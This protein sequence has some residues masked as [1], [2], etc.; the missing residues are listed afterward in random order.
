MSDKQYKFCYS[1]KH[2]IIQIGLHS[3]CAREALKG[4]IDGVNGNEASAST[5]QTTADEG[6]KCGHGGRCGGARKRA[7]D[8][9]R[10]G[11][12]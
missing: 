10:A 3:E 8:R 4:Y 6:E 5:V 12:W 9:E 7:R 1:N 2:R 11:G